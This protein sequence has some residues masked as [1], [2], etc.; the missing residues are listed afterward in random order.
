MEKKM[1]QISEDSVEQS[2]ALFL[3]RVAVEEQNRFARRLIAGLSAFFLLWLAALLYFKQPILQS[4]LP[5]GQSGGPPS[6]SGGETFH[7]TQVEQLNR[8]LTR[9]QQQL[10]SALT[11]TLSVKLEELEQRIRLGRAGLQ[12]LEL[13]QSIREDIRTLSKQTNPRLPVTTAPPTGSLGASSSAVTNLG[14]GTVEPVL[15]TKIARLENLLYFSLASFVLV[16]VAAAGYWLR[17]GT[18]LRR[19]DADLARLRYQLEHQQR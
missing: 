4:W 12:D 5:K 19:L 7:S 10:G 13:I 3:A 8:E 17:C 15:L 9:L 11:Q 1:K 2:D 14:S 16:T 18:R 6:S